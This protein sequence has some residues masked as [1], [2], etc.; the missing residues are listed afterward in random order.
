[1]FP[2]KQKPTLMLIDS[3]A[4]LHRSYH[5][6][7]DFYSREGLPSGALYGFLRMIQSARKLIN[8]DYV[9]ACYDLPKPTFRHIAYEDYKGH[10]A[11]TDSDL[12]SQITE[13]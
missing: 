10:R 1:M 12:V 4:L 3:H 11:K 9:I 2:N 13:S 8:P 6:M 5:A 7:S